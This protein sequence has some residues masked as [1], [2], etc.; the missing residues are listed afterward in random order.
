MSESEQL[1]PAASPL[2]RDLAV[3]HDIPV[4]ISIDVGRLKLT[5]R[6]FLRLAPGSVLEIK[7]AA[8]E[9]FE[10][11][12]NGHPVGRGE[13]VMVEQSSGVRLVELFKPA[14]AV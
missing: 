2:L 9:P 8:G 3:I 12:L 1:V 6:E 14:G 7:K 11:A 13:V 5:V 4:R 10:V